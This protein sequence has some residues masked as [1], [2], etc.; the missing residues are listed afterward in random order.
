MRA[1][2]NRVTNEGSYKD[3]SYDFEQPLTTA[4]SGASPKGEALIGR[5]RLSQYSPAVAHRRTP[6]SFRA[7]VEKS[8]TVET[9]TTVHV[10]RRDE[11]VPPYRRLRRES[12]T[13]S[14]RALVEKSPAIET[15]RYV[16]APAHLPM[17]A[18]HREIPRGRNENKR[19]R[20]SQILAGGGSPPRRFTEEKPL[21]ERKG[22]PA[23]LIF[24]S[25]VFT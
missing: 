14:F 8:P 9:R 12:D 16:H 7:L 2:A 6:M 15:A 11:G 5:T 1:L 19:T 3:E 24:L 18:R 10:M 25:A 4:Y 23:F 22:F 21:P 17:A 13:M 20:L